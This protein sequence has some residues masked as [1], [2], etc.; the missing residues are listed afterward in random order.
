MCVNWLAPIHVGKII[1]IYQDDLTSISKKRTQHIQNMW[2]IFERCRE[3]GVS[4]NPKNIPLPK[5]KKY[6]QSFFGKIDFISRFIPNFIDIFKPLNHFLKWD[7][8]FKWDNNG[9][10]D[11]QHMKEAITIAPVLVSLDFTKYFIIFSF[12]SNDT[13]IGVLLK[14]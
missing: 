11:L 4:L 14:K 2:V 13:I 10:R 5:D 7:T 12:S 9:K 3:Y 8:L 1:E 6:L